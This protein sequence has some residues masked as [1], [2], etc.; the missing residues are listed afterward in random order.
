MLINTESLC[1]VT[2]N[3]HLKQR[4]VKREKI[5]KKQVC[6]PVGYLPLVGWPYWDGGV[7]RHPQADT[8]LF[9]TS[10]YTRLLI[11]HP[12]YTTSPCC[13]SVPWPL[14]H[15]PLYTTTLYTMPHIYHMPSIPHIPLY[16]TPPPSIPHHPLCHRPPSIQHP[17][18]PPS[19]SWTEW[20]TQVKTLLAPYFV[21]GC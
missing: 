15:S 12:L 9:T 6:I 5:K 17:S 20:R 16:Y 2:I 4:N 13:P 10:L 19:P 21:C 11:L 14:Y 1:Y 3:N 18:I 8:P 7:G